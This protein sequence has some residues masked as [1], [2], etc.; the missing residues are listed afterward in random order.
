MMVKLVMR[1]LFGD[2]EFTG[3]LLLFEDELELL[4][5]HCQLFVEILSSDELSVFPFSCARSQVCHTRII[6][7][8]F[9]CDC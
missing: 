3:S 5:E 1:N 6:F 4:V 7:V 9:V 2:E 8:I